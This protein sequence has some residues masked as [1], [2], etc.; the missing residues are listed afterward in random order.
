MVAVHPQPSS[1]Y[2]NETVQHR[3]QKRKEVDMDL[4]DIVGPTM[5]SEQR[6]VPADTK[7]E[8]DASLAE[9]K[10]VGT[11]EGVFTLPDG[12]GHEA[13]DIDL[14]PADESGNETTVDGDDAI[15]DEQR[16]A[17]DASGAYELPY[18]EASRLELH[19]FCE[20]MPPMNDDELQSLVNDI[21]INGQ[22]DPVVVFDGKILDGRNRHR[23]H[24]EI[25]VDGGSEC[26][27]LV[28]EFTGTEQDAQEY[29]IAACC[30]RRSLT[31]SQKALVAVGLMEKVRDDVHEARRQ[32]LQARAAGRITWDDSGQDLPTADKNESSAPPNRVRDVVANMVGV[33]GR[34]MGN[35]KRLAEAAESDEGA[36]A[37]LE[38]VR[39]GE[40][41]LGK[42]IENLKGGESDEGDDA[43]EAQAVATE[44]ES[45]Q[46]DASDDDPEDT[47]TTEPD[48][49]DGPSETDG[50]ETDADCSA[51]PGQIDVQTNPDQSP[52][53]DER[54]TGPSSGIPAEQRTEAV[55]TDIV[56]VRRLYEELVSV[57]SSDRPVLC[58]AVEHLGEALE[59]EEGC[60]QEE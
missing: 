60:D 22:H 2:R 3:H 45:P 38:S 18:D 28:R 4:R 44:D 46:P 34:L 31:K 20:M 39:K 37:D 14:G 49:P 10:G 7:K 30:Q 43:A 35:A 59:A 23:A 13:M 6:D 32:K 36:S 47:H 15:A 54:V 24:C 42:A 27:L 29:V 33:S 41:G 53:D 55:S 5:E 56:A 19:P 21:G 40:I 1:E 12:Y 16:D 51:G 52:D 11:P 57:V 58:L 25:A 50:E 17:P 8:A 26:G 48:D 9:E